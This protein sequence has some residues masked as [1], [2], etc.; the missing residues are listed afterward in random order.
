MKFFVTIIFSWQCSGIFNLLTKTMILKFLCCLF[1]PTK[2]IMEKPCNLNRYITRVWPW[3]APEQHLVA[4]L[5]T[6]FGHLNYPGG[7]SKLSSRWSPVRGCIVMA[8]SADQGRNHCS[9]AT[10]HQHQTH[11]QY[12]GHSGHWSWSYHTLGLW[13]TWNSGFSTMASP[14]HHLICLPWCFQESSSNHQ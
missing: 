6:S 13:N 4:T 10:T 9:Q 12:L 2:L 8:T 3:L 1:H 14:T 5:W 11:L 7:S